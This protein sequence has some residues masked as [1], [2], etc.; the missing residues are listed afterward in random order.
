MEGNTGVKANVPTSR[1]NFPY[2]R[3]ARSC[4]A[5]RSFQREVLGQGLGG[6]HEGSARKTPRAR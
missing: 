6:P 4:L 5:A 3:R 1:A 2:N